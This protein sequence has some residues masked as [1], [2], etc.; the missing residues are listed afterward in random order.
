MMSFG[1]LGKY[2]MKNDDDQILT[3]DEMKKIQKEQK[4]IVLKA[5][6]L[7]ST[8]DQKEEI[9]KVLIEEFSNN[10]KDI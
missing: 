4:I 6:S 8:S 5:L 2:N 7:F 1:V 9:V 3:S 10:D